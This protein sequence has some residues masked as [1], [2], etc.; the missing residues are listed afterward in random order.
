VE[1]GERRKEL[2][3]RKEGR[4]KDGRNPEMATKAEK[5]CKNLVDVE[6]V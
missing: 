1:G 6:R 5:M 2:K 3:L 4:K